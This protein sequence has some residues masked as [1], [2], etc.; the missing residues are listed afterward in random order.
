MPFLGDMSSG[1]CLFFVLF[2][3]ELEDAVDYGSD[4]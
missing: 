3:I 1:C 4:A 2:D